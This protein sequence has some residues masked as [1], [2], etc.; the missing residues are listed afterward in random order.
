MSSLVN[1]ALLFE[2]SDDLWLPTS[3][4]LLPDEPDPATVAIESNADALV[5]ARFEP[6]N[7]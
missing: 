1:F 4:N 3:E 5:I 7:L 2:L 6:F